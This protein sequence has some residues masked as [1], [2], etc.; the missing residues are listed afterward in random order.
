MKNILFS[1][2]LAFQVIGQTQTI[3]T[4]EYQYENVALEIVTKWVQ[5][6]RVNN[7]LQN[8]GVSCSAMPPN[9]ICRISLPNLN[10]AIKNIITVT[11]SDPD[12]SY[13]AVLNYNPVMK[14]PDSPK[15]PTGLVIKTTTTTV[16]G[17]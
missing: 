13:Q 11:V 10:T 4:L 15:L 7:V 6:V 5:D 2:L 16:I 14:F 1:G 9:V 12:E 17:Q 8:T 3:Q